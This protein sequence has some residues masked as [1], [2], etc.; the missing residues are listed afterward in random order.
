MLE[1]A[2]SI[3]STISRASMVGSLT[4]WLE[5]SPAS[6]F[7]KLVLW[8]DPDFTAGCPGIAASSAAVRR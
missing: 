4:L 1:K 8:R 6:H 7:S 3:R 2:P 5:S